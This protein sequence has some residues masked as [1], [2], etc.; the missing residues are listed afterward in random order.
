MTLKIEDFAS[1]LAIFY[2]CV[3]AVFILIYE[4][5]KKYSF[6]PFSGIVLFSSYFLFELVFVPF[7]RFVTMSDHYGWGTWYGRSGWLDNNFVVYATTFN[8]FA[9]WLFAAG[10]YTVNQNV[11][12]RR[13]KESRYSL[14]QRSSMWISIV[15]SVSAGL[16]VLVQLY[17][18][19]GLGE[20]VSVETVLR[21]AVFERAAVYSSDPSLS[22]IV[23]LI[24]IL[25]GVLTIIILAAFVPLCLNS[26]NRA[27][28]FNW[29]IALCVVLAYGALSGYRLP[30]I[31]PL[32]TPLVLL[33][34]FGK[35]SQYTLKRI[36][37]W[38]VVSFIFLVIA[39]SHL[40]SKVATSVA[41][42]RKISWAALT[43]ENAGNK[44]DHTQNLLDDTTSLVTRDTFAAIWAIMN[45]YS[46]NDA[47][48]NGQTFVDVM[49]SLIPRRI[50]PEKKMVYG[51]DEVTS[52]MDLPLT[53]HTAIGIHGE[54]FANF[55]YL[56]IIGMIIYGG[57]FGFID[58]NKKKNIITLLVFATYLGTARVLVHLDF[59]FTALFISAYTGLCY[60]IVL[61]IIFYK[62]IRN[63][64]FDRAMQTL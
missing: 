36:T 39:F 42:H 61:R 2:L 11:F 9:Y 3:S 19:A 60:W 59:G 13:G 16:L 7:I 43:S 20:G 18:L 56:G 22:F 23:S 12:L 31:W 30:V 29:L 15:V 47:S 37:L 54:L 57:I 49:M 34:Y 44:V 50:W 48:L 1:F 10:Y 26:K 40:Q 17:W 21:R 35:F 58:K 46:R 64:R 33:F 27:F 52:H 8:L 14:K 38:T 51:S 53:T 45:Y 25:S 4:W 55:S 41:E 24:Q 62:R 63:D 28:K 5:K 32:V 6:D